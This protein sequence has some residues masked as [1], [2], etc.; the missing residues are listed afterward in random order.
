MKIIQ[1]TATSAWDESIRD[2]HERIY[3]LGD[4]QKMYVWDVSEG[5]WLPVSPYNI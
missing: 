3:G 5:I 4:D 2:V 1:I